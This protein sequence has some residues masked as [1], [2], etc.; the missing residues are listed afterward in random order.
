MLSLICWKTKNFSLSSIACDE[1][2]ICHVIKKF[3]DVYPIDPSI[4][5]CVSPKGPD[6]DYAKVEFVAPMAPSITKDKPCA[7]D[8]GSMSDYCRFA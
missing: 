1:V 6:L 3:D 7:I 8:E 4:S 5:D 2:T